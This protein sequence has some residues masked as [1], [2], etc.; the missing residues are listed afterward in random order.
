[1]SLW[2]NVKKFAQPYA[3][4]D[5]DDYD[6]DDDY[7]D[8]YEEPAEAPARVRPSE[9]AHTAPALECLAYIIAQRADI[10]ALAATDIKQIILPASADKVYAV[11]GNASRGALDLF[12]FAGDLIQAL[13]VHLNS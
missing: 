1:M 4:D 10:G 7:A 5:Y 13:S 8:E 9:T 3:D 2:D 12:S 6:E 11:D